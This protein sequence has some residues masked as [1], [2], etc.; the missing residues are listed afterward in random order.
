VATLETAQHA[1]LERERILAIGAALVAV[2]LW[3]SAFVGIRS[4][5][6][7]FA[8]GALALGRLVV[9]SVALGVLVLARREQFPAWRDLLGIA[10]CGIFW[11]G[12]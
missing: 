4:A 3:A 10:F 12:I 7:D 1:P 8:P 5:G 6:H 2:T 11:F 9:G